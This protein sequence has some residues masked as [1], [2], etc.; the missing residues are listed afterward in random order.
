[1]KWDYKPEEL[2]DLANE[3]VKKHNA[4]VNAVLAIKE[5]RNFNNTVMPVLKADYEYDRLSNSLNFLKSVTPNKELK[6]AITN[7]EVI[8]DGYN[9]N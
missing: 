5:R 2:N 9:L 1:M 6:Q 7:A 3:A 4:S 8:L